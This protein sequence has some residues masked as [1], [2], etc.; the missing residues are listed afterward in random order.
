MKSLII[1]GLLWVSLFLP[2]LSQS[3][4]FSSRELLSGAINSHL[5]EYAA[6]ANAG[7]DTLYFTRKGHDSNIGGAQGSGDIWMAVRSTFGWN[8]ETESVPLPDLNSK[9][10]NRIV[11][12]SSAG[13]ILYV[14]D[15]KG[16]ITKYIRKGDNWVSLGKLKVKGISRNH[17]GIFVGENE[18]YILVSQPGKENK[19]GNDLYILLK[20]GANNW[21][22]PKNLGPTIN[23]T[24]NECFPFLSSDKKHLF[25]SS[26][27]H[28]G[29]G[30]FDIFVSERLYD[31]WSVWGKPK[32]LGATINSMGSENQFYLIDDKAYFNS[33]FPDGKSNIYVSKLLDKPERSKEVARILDESKK[34][35]DEI[36]GGFAIYRSEI[37]T[38]EKDNHLLS[39]TEKT[40][41]G[42]IYE[43]LLDNPSYVLIVGYDTPN[44]SYSGWMKVLQEKRIERVVKFLQSLGI[45][46]EKIKYEIPTTNEKTPAKDTG[47]LRVVMGK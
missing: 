37:L 42:E 44:E 36:S 27:G 12:R 40:L 35:V 31:S 22:S 24:G 26:D 19:K 23:S 33:S 30:G 39:N 11:G 8:W 9:S 32:N 25:F 21:S 14:S 3:L 15:D 17:Q 13:D 6:L 4:N 34:L 41:L 28:K 46:D 47:K 18:D 20:E 16:A 1:A 10:E 7:G 43:D 29:L 2:V 5:E 45:P 38:F